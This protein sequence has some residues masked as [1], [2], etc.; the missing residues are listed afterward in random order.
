MTRGAVAVCVALGVVG[1]GGCA[2]P[3]RSTPAEQSAAM[4]LLGITRHYERATTPHRRAVR[5]PVR[6]E[7]ALALRTLARQADALLAET[8]SWDSAP[9]LVSLAENERSS[10]S[11]TVVAFRESLEQLR[12]AAAAGDV[13]QVR[14]H[15]TR[16][17]DACWEAQRAVGAA[18]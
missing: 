4:G 13:A 7:R 14:R 16:T 6:D 8:R 11:E 12:D 17:L 5:K 1:L 3:P 9:R 10:A 18:K 15:Y 2:A